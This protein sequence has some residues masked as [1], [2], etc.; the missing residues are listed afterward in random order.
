MSFPFFWCDMSANKLHYHQLKNQDSLLLVSAAN[1]C[2]KVHQLYSTQRNWAELLCPRRRIY[3]SQRLHWNFDVLNCWLCFFCPFFSKKTVI[4]TTTR[5][6]LYP[7][8]T[9]PLYMLDIVITLWFRQQLQFLNFLTKIYIRD[10]QFF[11]SCSCASACVK[12][13]FSLEADTIEGCLYTISVVVS[14]STVNNQLS[15]IIS[16]ISEADNVDW[17]T[18]DL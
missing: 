3:L 1:L 16:I 7:R 15:C 18:F 14:Y 10:P 11:I 4:S 13:S 9:V 6:R 17:A 5:G 12:L 2:V 8:K